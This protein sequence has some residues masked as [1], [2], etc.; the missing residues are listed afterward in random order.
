MDKVTS[1]YKVGMDVSKDSFDVY[2]AEGGHARYSNDTEGF[3]AL[4]GT[5]SGD[6]HCVMESTGSYNQW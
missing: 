1:K 5:L 3:S 4:S 2:S 6:H